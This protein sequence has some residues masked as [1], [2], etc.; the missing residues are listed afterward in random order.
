MI[1]ARDHRRRRL[2]SEADP[3]ERTISRRWSRHRTSGSSSGRASASAT[4]PT[5][6]KRT[7]DL[8][9]KAAQQALERAGVEPEEIDFIVVGTTTGDMIFPTTA[10]LVQ[11]QLGCRNAGS[12]DVYAACAGSVYSL[13]IGAQYIQ[14]GKYRTV[15]CIGAEMPL[16]HHRLHR[17]GHV[18]P[19]GRRRG[20][21]GAAPLR[22][23]LAASS[24]PT[25][26]PTAAT[27]IC[28]SSRRAARATRRRHETVEQRMHYAQMKG[29]EVFKVAVRMFGECAEKIL[30]RNGFTAERPRRCSSRT[31]PTS[32]SSRPP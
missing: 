12:V 32:A 21:R 20:R 8:A 19:A 1:R 17:P 13:S 4:S 25:S 10:N 24:T 27:A 15:L 3:D 14:T 5:R 22:R 26:T 2:R 31:R 30:T 18:H 9:I 7:S 28:S 16:A 6:A 23:R 11:H 29:N